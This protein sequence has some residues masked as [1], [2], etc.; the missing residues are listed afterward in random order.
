LLCLGRLD[1]PYV[2]DEDTDPSEHAYHQV[3]S[4]D[5]WHDERGRQEGSPKIATMFVR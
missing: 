5:P 4:S 3:S 2:G 1:E